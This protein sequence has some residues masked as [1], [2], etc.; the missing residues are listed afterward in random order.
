MGVLDP[1]TAL[2]TK[3]STNSFFIIPKPLLLKLKR[4][5]IRFM[6]VIIL[7]HSVQSLQLPIGSLQAL[8][9]E[10]FLVLGAVVVVQHAELQVDLEQE[11]VVVQLH[12]ILVWGVVVM[13]P[14]LAGL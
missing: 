6:S 13:P 14:A 2:D 5:S 8:R 11:E 10:C 7:A 12:G 4:Q 3:Y 1:T 9:T